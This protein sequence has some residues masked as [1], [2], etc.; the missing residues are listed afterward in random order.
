M[1]R[2]HVVHDDFSVVSSGRV[3]DVLVLRTA[4]NTM[5]DDEFAG[6]FWHYLPYKFGID[7]PT[8]SWERFEM[9][10]V[11][12]VSRGGFPCVSKTELAGKG[13]VGCEDIRR[14]LAPSQDFDADG[15]A[16]RILSRTGG[17]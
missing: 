3:A 1:A 10:N 13:D 8:H 5:R 7:V 15:M 12:G 6:G 16:W 9:N 14:T 17:I 11:D 2:N 4:Y